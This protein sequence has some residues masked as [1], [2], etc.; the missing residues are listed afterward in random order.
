MM[1]ANEYNNLTA[2]DYNTMYH[3]FLKWSPEELMNRAG[4]K[5]GYIVVDLCCGANA[6]LTISALKM[7]ANSVHAV[8]KTKYV[9]S[10]HEKD[11]VPRKDWLKVLPFH[12]SV[13]EYLNSFRRMY[14]F[15]NGPFV[16]IV[17]SRQSINYFF[18]DLTDIE[19]G[20]LAG[21]IK[22]DGKFVF[23]TFRNC[24]PKDP[25]VKE[26][27]NKG[28]KF[29]EVY[30]SVERLVHHVQIA[31]GYPPHVTTFD[32]ITNE[33]FESKLHI[34]FGTIDIISREHTDIYICSQPI[35]TICT[36]K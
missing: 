8:D 35:R 30:W 23:N 16:D 2:E 21:M 13:K 9:K 29:V 31:E 24:P 18:N 36:K 28:K 25:I 5:E 12:M 20:L 22:D 19:L 32:H 11:V 15:P 34:A 10:L 6:L 17:A 33:E 14:A 1:R 7:G 4:M 3:R 27:F 26:Y